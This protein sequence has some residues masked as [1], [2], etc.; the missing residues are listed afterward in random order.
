MKFGIVWF[1]VVVFIIASFLHGC[2]PMPED[3]GWVFKRDITRV[4]EYCKGDNLGISKIRV[5]AYPVSRFTRTFKVVFVCN[6]GLSG[7]FSYEAAK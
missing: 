2:G 5:Q 7:Q 6:N 1:L 3:S 4:E